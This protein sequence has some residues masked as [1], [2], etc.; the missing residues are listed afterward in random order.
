MWY[1]WLLQITEFN[2]DSEKYSRSETTQISGFCKYMGVYQLS[3]AN[4]EEYQRESKNTD[5]NPKR[6][7]WQNQNNLL[8][9]FSNINSRRSK[10]SINVVLM[11]EID[12]QKIY[13]SKRAFKDPCINILSYSLLQKWPVF[14][15][16]KACSPLRMLFHDAMR[17]NI[18]NAIKTILFIYTCFIVLTSWQ[19]LLYLTLRLLTYPNVK[20][21]NLA[22]RLVSTYWIVPGKS[23]IADR[24]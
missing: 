4:C 21:S 23:D 8:S 20:W 16:F 14:G 12:S 6:K 1:T 10:W 15:E 2:T 13:K 24:S 11:N 22:L 19:V 3:R 7:L 17:N 5:P 18:S 9:E